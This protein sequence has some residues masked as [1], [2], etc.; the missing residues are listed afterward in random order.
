MPTQSIIITCGNPQCRKRLQINEPEKF[1][2]GAKCPCGYINLLPVMP[3]PPPVTSSGIGERPTAFQSDDDAPTGLGQRVQAPPQ[4][5]TPGWLIVKDEL[6]ESQTFTLHIGSNTI[7]RQS[8]DNPANHM[9]T[10]GDKYMSRPH[11]TLDVRLNKMGVLDFILQDGVALPKGAYKN[12]L[13]GTYVN[14]KETRLH[15]QDR[16]YLQDGDTI[17]IGITKL[18]LKTGYSAQ[19]TQQASQKV[20]DMDYERTVMNFINR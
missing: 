10:S 11:C 16:I 20:A 9:I 15:A 3:P 5:A 19:S 12:S 17:Q 13:N 18:V 1:T 6:T 7:G 2:K 14:G 8:V 4:P